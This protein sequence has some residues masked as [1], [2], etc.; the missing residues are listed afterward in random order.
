MFIRA[1]NLSRI[2]ASSTTK[3]IK[4]DINK[5]EVRTKTSMNKTTNKMQ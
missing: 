5:I 1:G 3:R 2:K 4:L